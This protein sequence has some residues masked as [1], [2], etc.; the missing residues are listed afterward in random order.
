MMMMMMM[1]MMMV[2]MVMMVMVMVMVIMITILLLMMVV[3]RSVI[4]PILHCGGSRLTQQHS[5]SHQSGPVT[6]A[7]GL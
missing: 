4:Q 7:I 3:N 1:M 6:S 5:P 2:M